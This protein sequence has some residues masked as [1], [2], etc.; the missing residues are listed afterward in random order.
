MTASHALSQLS[1]GPWGRRSLTRDDS[2]SEALRQEISTSDRTFR[3]LRPRGRSI[4]N[5][6]LAPWKAK[7][8]RSVRSQL[9]LNR[10]RPWALEAPPTRSRL[11]RA[12]GHRAMEATTASAPPRVQELV[13]ARIGWG[14]PRPLALFRPRAGRGSS[15][16]GCSG[17]AHSPQAFGPAG[18]WP[19]CPGAIA[20][21]GGVVSLR[22]E[23]RRAT[24]SHPSQ[25]G[26]SA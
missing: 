3:Q 16:D 11:P 17:P 6:G 26:S 19:E 24:P 2:R 18:A 15:T 20:H 10:P 1:Y 4:T 25:L 7:E 21:R 14:V 22:N 12:E 8:R 23:D 5:S 9:A 13:R